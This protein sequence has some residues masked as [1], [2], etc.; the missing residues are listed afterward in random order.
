MNK[1]CRKTIFQIIPNGNQ[2]CGGTAVFACLKERKRLAWL[3]YCPRQYFVSMNQ[4]G[5]ICY[6]VYQCTGCTWGCKR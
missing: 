1:P 4:V 6:K 3:N 5:D 2:D